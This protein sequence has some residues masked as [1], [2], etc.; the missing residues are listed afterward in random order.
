M[1]GDEERKR[2]VTQVIER[3]DSKSKNLFIT[4]EASNRKMEKSIEIKK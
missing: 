1:E 2:F 4:S 3:A